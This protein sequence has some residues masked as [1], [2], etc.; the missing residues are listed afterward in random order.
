M[1]FLPKM[2]SKLSVSQKSINSWRIFS[3]CVYFYR[4]DIEKIPNDCVSVG[5]KLSFWEVCR[6]VVEEFAIWHSRKR[7]KRVAIRLVAMVFFHNQ[8]CSP[9]IGHKKRQGHRGLCN[10]KSSSRSDK[11]NRRSNFEAR[12]AF[13]R[14][15]FSVSACISV[16]KHKKW[17]RHDDRA[18]IN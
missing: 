13:T 15:F 7:D 10:E 2:F 16:A 1:P 6:L 14:V 12:V 9:N 4:H 3:E 11:K 5:R 8:H 17:S 18:E